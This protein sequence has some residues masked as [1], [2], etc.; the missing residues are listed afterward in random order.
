MGNPLQSQEP[1]IAVVEGPGVHI[2]DEARSQLRRV[3]GLAGCVRAVGMPDLHPG[4]GIPIGMVTAST[5]HVHPTLV[6]SDA[7]C[8]VTAA[9]ALR[10]VPVGKRLRRIDAATAQ[11]AGFDVDPLAALEAAWHG[12]PAGLAE[13]AEC[14]EDFRGW[15]Q[16]CAWGHVHGPSGPLPE[17]LREA[18]FGEDLGTIGGGNHF[19]ELARVDRVEQDGA[20]AGLRRGAFVVLAHSGSRGLGYALI[21]RWHERSLHEPDEIARYLGELAG[22]CRFAQANRAL[23][24]WSVLQAVGSGRADRIGGTLDLVHNDVTRDTAPE[25]DSQATWLHRKGAAPARDGE[26]TITLG[27]RGAPSWIL[28]GH[29]DQA[30]LCSVA[31]GAGRQIPRT[32]AKGR[33]AHRY[34]RAQLDRSRSGGQV[35][36]E[37]KDLLWEEHP[38]V[39]KP[40]EPV[41]AALEAAGIATRVASLVPEVTV[42]R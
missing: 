27:S 36:C 38:D 40:I 39:Y 35:L 20:L 30:H 4:P 8:G 18:R 34:R 17:V 13:L 11:P 6:G 14:P 33:L 31:H 29:G 10:V 25:P 32:E 22:C 19:V 24:V 42:K 26:L 23:L 5:S 9:V 21:Q 1:A 37:R 16:G 41:V 28:R 3:A 2:E 12:G 7:G 15:V